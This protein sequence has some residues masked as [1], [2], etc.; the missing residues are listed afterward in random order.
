[1]LLFAVRDRPELPRPVPDRVAVLEAAERFDTVDLALEPDRADCFLADRADC[2]LADRAD[3]FLADRAD[4]FLADRADCFL[5]DRADCFLAGLGRS[6][7]PLPDPDPDPDLAEEPRVELDLD[8]RL[9]VEDLDRVVGFVRLEFG[10]RAPVI[11]F[12]S[13]SLQAG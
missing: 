4:C 1:L 8:E 2:F 7:E 3:C 11:N 9:D 6:R 5:T 10:R 13:F 12:Q